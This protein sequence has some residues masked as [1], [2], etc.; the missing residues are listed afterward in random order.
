M[1]RAAKSWGTLL[2]SSPSWEARRSDG[3]FAGQVRAV[4]RTFSKRRAAELFG[5]SLHQ[6]NLYAGETGN[7]EELAALDAHPPETVLVAGSQPG[8]TIGG[9]TGFVVRPST[10]GR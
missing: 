1:T 5:I 4:V 8:D 3:R 10:V 9:E 7:A 6:F 2:M